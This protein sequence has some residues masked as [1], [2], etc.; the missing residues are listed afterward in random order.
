M[1]L[2]GA[3][4]AALAWTLTYGLHST[5]W[6]GAAW[7]ATRAL[8]RRRYALRDAIWKA[9]LIG[10]LA[11]AGLQLAFDVAPLGG[12]LDVG[13]PEAV[14]TF[15]ASADAPPAA[16]P[17]GDYAA[18]AVEALSFHWRHLVVGLWALGGV[19]GLALLGLAWRRIADLLHGRLPVRR[20]P[21]RERY[22]A[23]VARAGVRRAPRLCL[24]K[25]LHS[26]ATVGVFL[27][28]V[29]VPLRAVQELDGR[30]QEAMLAHELAHVVRRDPLWQAFARL[31]ERACFFQ[32]LNRVARAE[33]EELAEF[34]A[35]DWAVQLTRDEVGL[36]RCLTEVATWVLGPRP[37]VAVLPMAARG[38]RL[39]ARVEALLEERPREVHG[40]RPLRRALFTAL[41][42]GAVV[43]A[44]GVAAVEHP[45]LAGS[46]LES[47]ARSARDLPLASAIAP[48]LADL[49]GTLD[50]TLDELVSE[51]DALEHDLQGRALSPEAASVAAELARRT[52]A[53]RE[54]RASLH[55]RVS[56]LDPAVGGS[57]SVTT[58]SQQEG[59]R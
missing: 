19:V 7:L 51:V 46:A 28:Q 44:P 54:R 45:F 59:N 9:A 37:V 13:E 3:V 43:A 48:D 27:P 8:G 10:G 11:S 31:V 14:A 56:G 36:A 6:L 47:L 58:T 35:D 5:L 24:S 53:L 1:S 2:A 4:Q 29:C 30:A 22:D 38:S 40:P 12:R 16:A 34:L 18:R 21:L 41:L 15:A 26:P 17:T 50:A 52:A 57:T 23:L 25:H 32:P 55:R 42:G 33:L 39:A 20:G 49:L